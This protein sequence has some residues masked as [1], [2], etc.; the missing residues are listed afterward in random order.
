MF[1]GLKNGKG[2]VPEPVACHIHKHL[3]FW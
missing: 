2:Q 3:V 1:K